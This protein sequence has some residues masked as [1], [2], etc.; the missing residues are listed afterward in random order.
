MAPAHTSGPGLRERKKELTQ[1]TLRAAAFRLFAEKDFATVSVDEIA[2][3]AGVSRS[4]FFRYF[5]SKEAVLFNNVDETGNEFMKKLEQRPTAESPWTAYEK[6]MT[7]M[8]GSVTGTRDEQGRILDRL[9]RDD[10]AL[11]GRRLVV[12]EQWSEK[13]AR[14]F[15]TRA[16]RAEPNM[17]DRLAAATCLAVGEEIT[18]TW[19]EEGIEATPRS[20]KEAFACLRSF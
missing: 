10:P 15:A 5:G 2:T 20:V 6:V 19:R 8:I 18:R 11:A 17:E 14:T 4:T 3:E 9:L 1:E 16:G 13:V 7:E 12:L